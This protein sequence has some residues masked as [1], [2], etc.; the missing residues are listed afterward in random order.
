MATVALSAVGLMPRS[1]GIERYAR[2][3]VDAVVQSPPRGV[4]VVPVVRAWLASAVGLERGD[5]VVVPDA[6]PAPLAVEGLPML[7]RRLRPDL[8]HGL[9]LAVPR[10]TVLARSES[11]GASPWV[12]MVHDS[13][14]WEEKPAQ[15]SK[16]ARWYYGPALRSAARSQRLSAIVTT[17]ESAAAAIRPHVP[18]TLAVTALGAAGFPLPEVGAS[19]RE[20]VGGC[21]PVA[22]SPDAFVVVSVGTVEPRKGLGVLASAVGAL[23]ERGVAVTWWHVGRMG[24]GTLPGGCEYLGPISDAELSNVLRTADVFVSASLDEGFNMAA[25][26]AIAAGVTCVLSDIPAHR[27]NYRQSADL[28]PPGDSAALREAL[29]SLSR[30]PAGVTSQA[31]ESSSPAP[32]SA[33]PSGA[34][35]S[36]TTVAAR[37]GAVW[38]SLI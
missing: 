27:E 8:V 33:S 6:I 38:E 1:T 13:M 17:T 19:G 15:L 30:Q 14:L 22:K 2:A 34:H 9:D 37:A 12:Q 16:G 18:V 25:A 21:A 3:F 23:R 32:A 35:W 7:L 4:T 20:S 10:S 36:W 11:S 29:L 24:W 28:V 31:A 5:G 26:E